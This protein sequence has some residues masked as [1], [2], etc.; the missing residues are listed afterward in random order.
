MPKYLLILTTLH[1]HPKQF[2]YIFIVHLEYYVVFLEYRLIFTRIPETDFFVWSIGYDKTVQD[3]V[4][5]VEFGF[6][7]AFQQIIQLYFGILKSPNVPQPFGVDERHALPLAFIHPQDKIR[8]EVICLKE[9]N[10]L[11]AFIAQQI[12]ILASKNIVLVLVIIIADMLH[13]G[14]FAY[15][16]RHWRYLYQRFV[17]VL[18]KHYL[19]P[20]VISVSQATQRLIQ[21]AV[22]T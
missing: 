13:K 3:D 5:I 6:N 15:I 9:T 19:F 7:L 22:K 17:G 20:P 11:S 16:Q 8:I 2:T 12:Y 10:P 14:L 4:R 1:Y 21:V 18:V